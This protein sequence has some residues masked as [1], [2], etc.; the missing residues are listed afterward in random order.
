[1]NC[2]AITICKDYAV[3]TLYYFLQSLLL[4]ASFDEIKM[5][6]KR[7]DEH[8]LTKPNLVLQLDPASTIWGS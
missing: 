1:M 2:T 8:F 5:N 7:V 6:I 3:A 4:F